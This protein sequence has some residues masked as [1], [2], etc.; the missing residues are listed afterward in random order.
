M[1]SEG[2]FNSM[3]TV[4]VDSSKAG[5]VAGVAMEFPTTDDTASLQRITRRLQRRLSESKTSSPSTVEEIEAELRDADLRRQVQLRLGL[6]GSQSLKEQQPWITQK[7]KS[8]S[9]QARP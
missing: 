4:G 1:S 7:M 5:R 2:V 9:R 8:S 6:P 3:M